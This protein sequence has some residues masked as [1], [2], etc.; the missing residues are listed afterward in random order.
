MTRKRLAW[1]IAALFVLMLVLWMATSDNALCVSTYRI[2]S[3]RLPDAFDGFKIAQVSDLH[4][5]DIC[6][7]LSAMLADIKPDIIVITGDM[8]DSRRTDTDN[9]LRFAKAVAEAFPCYYVPGNHEAR[10]PEKYATLCDGLRALGVTVLENEG[11]DISLG[12]ESIRLVGV[13]DPNFSR[14]DDE[15]VMRDALDGLAAHGGYTVLLSHRPELFDVYAEYGADLV[16]SGHAHGGQFRL[17]L[18]GGVAAPDQGFFPKY[19][20][21]LFEK[22]KTSM[23]VSRGI[24]NSIIPLRIHNPPEIVVA[25]LCVE[26]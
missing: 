25:E 6:E 15:A 5:A 23:L 21:G 26:E 1:G 22:G 3:A 20:A 8:I 7:E 2:E 11:A 19:D 13:K 14:G 17:P 24:G 4:N 9:A 12:G 10:I 18:V 16:F